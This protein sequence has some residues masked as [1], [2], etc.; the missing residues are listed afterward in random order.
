MLKIFSLTI[1]LFLSDFY[2]SLAYPDWDISSIPVGL[3]KDAI[4][5]IRKSN[6]IL[7][8]QSPSKVTKKIDYAITI[9]NEKG[10]DYGNLYIGYD[11]FSQVRNIELAV[12]SKD[13]VQIRKIKN[14][15]IRDQSY[16]SDYTLYSDFRIKYFEIYQNSY[17]YTV[18]YSY[19]TEY[20]GM[21]GYPPWQPVRFYNVSVEQADMEVILDSGMKLHYKQCNVPADAEIKETEEGTIFHWKV[22]NIPAFVEELFSPYLVD[23]TPVVHMAPDEFYFDGAS[24][25]SGSWESLGTWINGLIKSRDILPEETVSKIK[26]MVSG[27]DD[28]RQKARIVYEYM[29]SKTRYVSIQMGIGGFQPFPASEVD[30]VGYGDCKAL[31]N[32]T[33]ALLS[34]A[35]IKSYYTVIGSGPEYEIKFD[36]FCSISQ[37]NHVIICVVCKG[38]TVWLECTSQKIPFG[39]ISRNNAGRRALLI[40]ENGGKLVRTPEYPSDINT[41]VRNAN[42]TIYEDKHAAVEIKTVYSGLQYENVAGIINGSSKEQKDHL[43][44]TLHL[45]DFEIT[46]FSYSEIKDIIPE[47]SEN[48]SVNINNYAS[49]AGNRLII[50]MNL[51]NRWH[52]LPDSTKERKTDIV[53]RMPFYDCDTIRYKIPQ[54]WIPDFLPENQK[55]ISVFGEYLSSVSFTANT[56]T[57]SRNL[58][59][60]KGTYPPDKYDEF[61]KFFIS[62]C[63]SDNCKAILVKE[64]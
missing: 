7:N 19:E 8:I 30:K 11:N 60:N 25:N 62:V 41:Q 23:H 58:R 54:N 22:I 57:Y 18:E 63:K 35:G 6:T 42:A 12:Y 17:P 33:A 10:K 48:I 1:L 59:I 45:N 2:P 36:D 31:S 56:I 52:Y 21:V 38:D 47:A 50:P 5:V 53:F 39:Y 29:Q 14:S 27:I 55:F 49:L 24:G 3:K 4:A 64:N 9:L 37:T 34:A 32:Y 15:D 13:G 43:Y 16:Y 51:L 44:E 61:V 28:D 46:G 40:N 26:S 20:S